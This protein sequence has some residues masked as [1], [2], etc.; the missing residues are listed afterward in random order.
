MAPRTALVTG[1]SRGIGRAIV[2]ELTRRDVR[3]LATGRNPDRLEALRV[4]TGCA[5]RPCDL[6]RPEEVLALYR[7][8]REILG[9]APDILVN[10]AGFYRKAPLAEASLEDFEAQ[11]AVLLRAPFLLCREAG[12]DMRDRGRGHIVNVLT[13]CALF[14]NENMG[15]YTAM[16]TGLQGLTKVLVKELRPAGVKVTAVYPGGVDTDIR[17]ASR[18]DYMS[19][20]TAGKLIADVLFAPD[21]AVIHEL[22]FRPMAE[23]NFP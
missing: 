14:A 21:D 15:I 16:K 18:P 11:Y 8:A 20:A 12:R 3:V 22:V 9:S 19:P 10:N 7:D 23:T 1:A 17:P 5:V 6:A 4:E 2:Q 13:T